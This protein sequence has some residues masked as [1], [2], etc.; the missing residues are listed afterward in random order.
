M[1]YQ[2]YISYI[3]I[4]TPTATRTHLLS[5]LRPLPADAACELDV[6][7]LDGHALG[8]DSAE[9]GVFEEADEVGFGSFLEG[10]DRRALP[11]EAF[12]VDF[13]GDLLHKALESDLADEE[14]G[15]LLIATYVAEGNGSRAVAMRF[16]VTYTSS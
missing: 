13:C 16:L 14:L 3:F 9:V 15:G 8:M 12:A 7:G 10:Q 2:L 11:P 6:L 4:R 1:Y 5:I